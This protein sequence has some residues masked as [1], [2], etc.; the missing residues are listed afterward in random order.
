MRHS[1]QR[2]G[3][4]VSLLR[5]VWVGLRRRNSGAFVP[6]RLTLVRFLAVVLECQPASDVVRTAVAP[7]TRELGQLAAVAAI[8]TA[9][10]YFLRRELAEDKRQVAEHDDQSTTQTSDQRQ[11]SGA[12]RTLTINAGCGSAA[13]SQAITACTLIAALVTTASAR[14]Q[15]SPRDS[16]SP[17]AC[18][19][20]PASP[21]GRRSP[22][23]RRSS[24]YGG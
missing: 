23:Q 20:C 19:G 22:P 1:G 9:L 14:N 11:P 18:C 12:G 21:A 10:N 3:R 2:R 8:R 13:T 16:W 24:S 6:V 4:G 7:R 17:Q 5:F 15:P